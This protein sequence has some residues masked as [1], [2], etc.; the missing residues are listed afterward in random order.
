M[1]LES[2]FGRLFTVGSPT[3]KALGTIILM[4]LMSHRLILAYVDWW[5]SVGSPI[6][7]SYARIVSVGKIGTGVIG[8]P[9][10]EKLG[11]NRLSTNLGSKLLGPDVN[12]RL[13]LV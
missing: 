8:S 3:N 2:L 10:R 4:N 13:G 5:S 6:N 7:L 12:V 9:E 11:T 1:G